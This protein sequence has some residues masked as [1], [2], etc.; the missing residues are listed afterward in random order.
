[1]SKDKDYMLAKNAVRSSLRRVFRRS[2]VYQDFIKSQRIEIEI[3]KK[4]GTPAKKKGVRFRCNLCKELFKSTEIDVDHI[5]PI[6]K[7]VY[8]LIRDAEKFYEVL[9]CKGKYANNLQIACK[10]CHKEK[11]KKERQSPSYHNCEF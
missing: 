1:M 5:I 3:L 8:D 11:S 4:D 6:G 10:V 9:F 7:G 2:S